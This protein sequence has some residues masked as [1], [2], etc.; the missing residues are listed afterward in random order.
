MTGAVIEGDSL[1]PRNIMPIS[2]VLY[3]A[4]KVTGV[5]SKT[6]S[7]VVEAKLRDSVI[8]KVWGE[9]VYVM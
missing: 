5:D 1:K 9:G 8:G 6:L 2:A 4:Q 7:F 3:A